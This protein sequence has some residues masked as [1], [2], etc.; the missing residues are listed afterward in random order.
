ML[1]TLEQPAA[2][3]SSEATDINAAGQIVGSASRLP[4]TGRRLFNGGVETIGV[5]WSG[6]TMTLLDRLV[7]AGINAAGQIVGYGRL[8]RDA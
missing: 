1:A 2:Y 3:V 4:T 8:W 5:L 7:P 6:G